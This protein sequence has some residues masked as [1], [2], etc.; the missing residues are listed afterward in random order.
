MLKEYPRFERGQ[1]QDFYD[2]LSK[3]EQQLFSDYITYRQAR[4][5][6]NPDKAKD[7]KRY[8]LQL[9]FILDKPFSKIELRELRS[10]LVVINNSWLADIP[11]NMIKVD[12]K[13]FLKY[14]FT[15]W[16]SRFA[17][18]EDIKLDSNPSRKR[19]ITPQILFKKEDIENIMLHE[20][21]MFWKAFFIVQYEGGMRTGEVRFLKWDDVKLNVD[22]DLSEITIYAT[23]TKK[24]RVVFVKEASHY[25]QRLKQEQENLNQKGIYIFHAARDKNKP[26]DKHVVSNWFRNLTGKVLNRGAWSYLLRHSRGTELRRLV[27]QGKISKDISVAFMGHS[28]KMNDS[29][30]HF[31]DQEIK[32]MLKNQVYKLEDIPEE[33]KHEL[34]GEIEKLKKENVN[35]KAGF[36]KELNDLRKEEDNKILELSSRIRNMFNASKKSSALNTVFVRAAEKDKRVVAGIKRYIRKKGKVQPAHP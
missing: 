13:N 3:E 12:L 23:K 28:E 1:I 2:K 11:K 10:L 24:N 21:K 20:P 35:L 17:N 18:L 8:L 27:K 9:R 33:K 32:E 7:T 26:V 31:E 19:P 30:S 14:L 4:G 22:G 16:S 34:E 15:D 5:L 36:E 25:L 29:Y 6:N